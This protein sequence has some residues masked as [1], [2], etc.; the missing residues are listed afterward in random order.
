VEK[1]FTGRAKTNT[2]A[3]VGMG[4]SIVY[5][6]TPLWI[7]SGLNLVPMPA[8]RPLF[9]VVLMCASCVLGMILRSYAMR[10]LGHFFSRQLRTEEDHK[11]ISEGPYAGAYSIQ[12]ISSPYTLQ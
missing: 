4:H 1:E 10:T 7:V 2:T 12:Y 11:V 8:F 6:G 9:V 3:L 5:L